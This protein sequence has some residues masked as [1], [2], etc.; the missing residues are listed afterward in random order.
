MKQLRFQ[1]LG[2]SMSL[3]TAAFAAIVFICF[4]CDRAAALTL[5]VVNSDNGLPARSVQWTDSA[6]QTRTA[7]M[8]DQRQGGAGYL[9]RLT[10]NVAGVGRV[11]TG[12]G[13]NGLHYGDGYVQNHTAAG[14]DF[15][16]HFV[17]GTTTV[18]LAG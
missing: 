10:Y 15:S 12:T 2:L 11:C 18:V 13:A 4:G 14:P 1:G 6:G 17:A 3:G 5:V 9:R 8:V 16:S 7:I